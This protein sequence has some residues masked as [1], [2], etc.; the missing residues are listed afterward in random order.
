MNANRMLVAGILALEMSASLAG[1]AASPPRPAPD[2]DTT[3]SDA[4]VLVVPPSRGFREW[5]AR[6]MSAHSLGYQQARRVR[7]RGGSGRAVFRAYEDAVCR[8][9]DTDLEVLCL[10][11]F[12]EQANDLA[13]RGGSGTQV[14]EL[15]GKVE[16]EC[17]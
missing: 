17:N 7:D 2:S 9:P 15:I 13:I 5:R 4:S 12:I 8:D 11:A 1:C 6:C 10:N 14:L 16:N 3:S